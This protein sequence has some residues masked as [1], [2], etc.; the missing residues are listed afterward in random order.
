MQ[1]RLPRSLL[2]HIRTDL[3]R[4]HAHAYE[5]IGF[6]FARVS[7]KMDTLL[8]IEYVPVSDTSYI[9]DDSV[10]AKIDSSAIRSALQKALTDE[11]AVFHVHAHMNLG[12]PRMSWTDVES[13]SKLVPS[14]YSAN[15]NAVHGAIILSEDS[16]GGWIWDQETSKFLPTDRIVSV[17][18]PTKIFFGESAH[19]D[20]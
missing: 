2:D 5:R 14:F 7:E 8:A 6:L 20:D 3:E 10:G 19:E 9:S 1:I 11:V 4:P 17:G 16:A 12:I 13:L 15:P 18:F